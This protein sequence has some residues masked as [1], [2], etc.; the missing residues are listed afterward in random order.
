MYIY[1][2]I[3]IYTYEFIYIYIY[4]YVYIIYIYIYKTMLKDRV[5]DEFRHFGVVD[6]LGSGSYFK[7]MLRL[8]AY[9][10][11]R[12]RVSSLRRC[13]S[14]W[15]AARASGSGSI[16]AAPTKQRHV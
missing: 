10:S 13:R 15:H 3:C 4:I 9:G 14:L 11:R 12:R 7:T 8:N 16:A 1:M 5:V 2:F 6:H